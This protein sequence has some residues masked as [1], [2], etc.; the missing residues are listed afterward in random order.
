[1]QDHR[2]SPSSQTTAGPPA[3][4]SNSLFLLWPRAERCLAAPPVHHAA[5]GPDG[6]ALPPEG[7]P[8]E[9]GLDGTDCPAAVK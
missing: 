4:T 8:G 7:R 6:V 1:M 9:P 5:G 3:A 2:K